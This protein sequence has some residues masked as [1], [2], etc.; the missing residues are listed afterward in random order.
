[1]NI[2]DVEVNKIYFLDD[3]Y[4]P[5][6][7]EDFSDDD[8]SLLKVL[9]VRKNNSHI[10]FAYRWTPSGE[11]REDEEYIGFE[12]CYFNFFLTPEEA[13]ISY[14]EKN[15]RLAKINNNKEIRD[16]YNELLNEAEAYLERLK[17]V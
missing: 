10:A 14:I 12:D 4:F 15:K 13:I 9:I 11:K 6:E 1:M 5:P 3:I 17:K 8:T 7:K 16:V 2:K